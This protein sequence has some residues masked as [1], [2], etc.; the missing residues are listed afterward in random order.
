MEGLMNWMVELNRNNHVGFGILTV[1][2]MSG[3]GIT[4]GV[5][6]ELFFK[7]ISIR[8]DNEKTNQEDSVDGTLS[9]DSRG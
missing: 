7:A 1:V 5:I 4:I 3:I 6:T 8:S 2:T 9:T